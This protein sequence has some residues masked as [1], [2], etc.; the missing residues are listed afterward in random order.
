MVLSSPRPL[1]AAPPAAVAWLEALLSA[2]P[3]SPVAT[4]VPGL[5]ARP[6]AQAALLQAPWPHRRQEHWRFTDPTPITAVPPQ[7]LVPHRAAPPAP[8]PEVARL[9]LDAG[10]DGLSAALLPAGVEPVPAAELAARTGAVLQ[11]CG[12]D[13]AWPVLFNTAT[14]ERLVAL[15]VTAA[16]PSTL[17][18]VADAGTASGVLPLRVLLLLEPDASLDVFQVQRAAG[19]SLTSLVLEAD[20]APG[21]RLRHSL[22]AQGDPRAVL[23]AHLAVRQAPGSHC[24]LTS[25]SSGWGLSRLEPQ[26]VQSAG[27]AH[28]RLRGL[29]VVHDRQIA[30]THSLVCFQGPDGVLD[31]EHR[32]V[33]DG[34]GRSVFNGAV[35]VPRAAQGTNAAQLSRNLLLSD[36]ARIDTKPEL[37]IVADDV[38]CRHGATVSRLQAEELFYLQSR[39]IGADQ[40]ARLLRR[41]FCGAVLTELP[42]A[43]APWDPLA[44]L[45]AAASLPPQP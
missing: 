8:G 44:G 31:Q 30:D 16:V 26:V 35:R 34:T 23:L 12:S 36:R 27:A 6:Q 14:A 28:S 19:S 21:A 4:D 25:V 39:G 5:A 11:A 3:S 38:S 45:I 20:L 15:R 24:S 10:A 1:S 29:Q 42:A 32:A 41:G 13:Q 18:L 7:L 9:Q 22:L 40:A 43:A 33:A 2:G 17:E 37:E